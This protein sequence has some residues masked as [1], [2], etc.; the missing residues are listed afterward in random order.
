M[1]LIT[2]TRKGLINFVIDPKDMQ[3]TIKTMMKYLHCYQEPIFVNL[4]IIF[5]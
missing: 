3:H 5:P 1:P 4:L 2:S